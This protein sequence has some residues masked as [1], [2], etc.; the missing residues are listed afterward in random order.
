M[1]QAVRSMA[2][3]SLLLFGMADLAW[4]NLKVFPRVHPRIARHQVAASIAVARPAPAATPV[5]ARE[6][7]VAAPASPATPS[8]APPEAPGADVPAT[9]RVYFAR[10]RYL[11]QDTSRDGIAAVAALAKAQPAGW[12]FVDGHADR[13]GPPAF[14]DRLSVKRASAVA[15]RLAARGI[16]RSRIVVRHFGASHPLVKADAS[17]GP[18]RNR[19]VD[20]TFVPPNPAAG[21]QH[22]R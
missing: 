12:I 11:P 15:D 17:A 4:L 6:T 10:N 21:D 1:T 5:P 2:T 7:I 19:R 14:N 18:R 22:E 20:I 9:R 13:S 8:P 3:A 16:D